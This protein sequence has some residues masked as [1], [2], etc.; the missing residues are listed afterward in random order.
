MKTNL[1]SLR[2][3]VG[4]VDGIN[5]PEIHGESWQTTALPHSR[6]EQSTTQ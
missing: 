5:I 1:T 2:E 3:L 4:R 6:A